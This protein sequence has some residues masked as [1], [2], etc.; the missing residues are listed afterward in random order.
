MTEDPYTPL[1]LGRYALKDLGA[2]MECESETITV[3][4]A[5]QKVVVFAF[6]KS[7]KEPMLEHFF[8]L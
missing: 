6:S 2:L 5:Q 1:I 8:F 3:R 7:S 4:V